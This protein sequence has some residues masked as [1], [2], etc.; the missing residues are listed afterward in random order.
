MRSV[1]M[2]FI[3]WKIM[4]TL[5]TYYTWCYFGVFLSLKL[6]QK[7]SPF[8]IQVLCSSEP[9]KNT[10]P[11]ATLLIRTGPRV[12]KWHANTFAI[13]TSWWYL[14]T[15]GSPSFFYFAHK[16]VRD[17]VWLHGCFRGSFYLCKFK[18]SSTSEYILICARSSYRN[19]FS[20]S[21]T[22]QLP[23]ANATEENKISDLLNVQYVLGFLGKAFKESFFI[24][25]SYSS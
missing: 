17:R 18:G 16:N 24:L 21:A 25:H 5:A 14:V 7:G 3:Q 22:P 19:I 8:D 13:S 4:Y 2:A 6:K 20:P 15:F 11:D 10:R 9:P 23:M 1:I 12:C